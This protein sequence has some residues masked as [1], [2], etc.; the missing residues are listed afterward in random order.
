MSLLRAFPLLVC[1][2][3][4]CVSASYHLFGETVTVAEE[5][6]QNGIPN[7][8]VISAATHQEC[9]GYFEVEKLEPIHLHAKPAKN[10]LNAEQ[11]AAS[12]A[13]Q[14]LSHASGADE[15]RLVHRYKVIAYMGALAP[16]RGNGAP[17]SQMDGSYS[18][19]PDSAGGQGAP[20]G[21][22]RGSLG[23]ASSSVTGGLSRMGESSA[24]LNLSLGSEMDRAPPPFVANILGKINARNFAENHARLERNQARIASSLAAAQN[25][26]MALRRAPSTAAA[27]EAYDPASPA[28]KGGD[29]EMTEITHVGADDAPAPPKQPSPSSH[30]VQ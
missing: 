30:R 8:V 1:A 4:V 14:A 28:Q 18:M 3:C 29:I 13:A 2:V 9:E 19:S 12:M 7:H 21:L 5:M 27:R 16:F 10:I 20:P 23:G 15:S 25:D 26:A 24:N 11:L 17:L 22:H 6:E